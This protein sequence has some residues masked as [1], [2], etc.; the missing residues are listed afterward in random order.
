R[1]LRFSRNASFSRS[2][3]ES[4]FAEPPIWLSRLCLSSLIVDPF[5][6]AAPQPYQWETSNDRPKAWAGAFAASD[7]RKLGSFRSFRRCRDP[8][9]IGVRTYFV[10][11]AYCAIADPRSRR[12]VAGA[13]DSGEDFREFY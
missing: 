12:D 10:S 7:P 13:D 4:F 5:E 1:R 2:C 3:R 11:L 8:A 9:A 6:C